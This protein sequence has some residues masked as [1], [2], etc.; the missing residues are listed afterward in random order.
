M[1]TQ[2]LSRLVGTRFCHWSSLPRR[3]QGL[4]AWDARSHR[5]RWYHLS[6]QTVPGT[7]EKLQQYLLHELTSPCTSPNLIF[8]KY[9][10]SGGGR[11][12]RY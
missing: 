4:K 8:E 9:V 7:R 1:G 12:T 5:L 11:Q 3:C 2:V 10:L 6:T